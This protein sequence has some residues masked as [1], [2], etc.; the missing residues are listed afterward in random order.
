MTA[1]T[2][3][4]MNPDKIAGLGL[5]EGEPFI[6]PDQVLEGVHKPRGEVLFSGGELV[7]EVYEDERATIAIAR[8]IPRCEQAESETA[9]ESPAGDGRRPAR[10]KRKPFQRG[11]ILRTNTGKINHSGSDEY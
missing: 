9:P 6:L 2:P 4:R 5:A 8:P 7:I 3:T 11:R 10:R 1:P